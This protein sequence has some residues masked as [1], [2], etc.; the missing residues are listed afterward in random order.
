MLKPK[1]NKFN[2]AKK[3]FKQ[4]KQQN[5]K[6]NN[7]FNLMDKFTVISL[8]VKINK[9][10]TCQYYISVPLPN[11]EMRYNISISEL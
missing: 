5:H 2:L 7:L 11:K 9:I 8:Q 4:W 6:N 10:K 3:N 1:G